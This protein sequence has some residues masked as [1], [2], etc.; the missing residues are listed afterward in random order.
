MRILLYRADGITD[1]WVA[2]FKSAL[3]EADVVIWQDGA[4]IAPCDYAVLWSPTAQ[5]LEQLAHVKA[6]FSTGAGV[7]A[8]L[9]FA[10]VLRQVPLIRLGDAGMAVQMAEYVAYAVLRYFRRF[11][12]YETLARQGQWQPLPQHQKQ[13]FSVGVMGMGVLGR[14]V[15]DTLAQF[16]FPLRGWSRNPKQIA[17]VTCFS[18]ADG[19]DEFLRGTRV[20][21]CMLPLTP[22]TAN[23]LD[24]A[25]LS[26]LPEGAYLVNVGRGGHVAEPDLLALIRSGHIAGVT[27]DVFREEPLP[28][29]HP[30]WGEQRITITPHTSA[31]TLPFDSAVQI[32]GKIVALE[33]G[34]P[35]A[36]VV[37]RTQGY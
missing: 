10:D 17:G 32:A 4:A 3:P 15:L 34:E 36:D 2:G 31:L 6:I 13:D 12:E 1:P 37:D 28:A 9:K 30:F 23:L 35:V 20:L 29:P 26:L 5:L 25:R 27:L 11:D 18:G 8:I 21:V 16:K 22:A 33:R 24:H 7:D 19:L 14:R